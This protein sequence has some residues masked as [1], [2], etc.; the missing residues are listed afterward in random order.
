MILS[1]NLKQGANPGAFAHGFA[2]HYNQI[3]P[4]KDLGL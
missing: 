3:V 1:R 4:R 2:I